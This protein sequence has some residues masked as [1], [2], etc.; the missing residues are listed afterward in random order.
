MQ[1]HT[2]VVFTENAVAVAQKQYIMIGLIVLH[3][4]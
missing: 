3:P 1:T 4:L 2:Y